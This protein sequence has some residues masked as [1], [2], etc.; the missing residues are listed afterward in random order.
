M[1]TFVKL[2][3]I[4]DTLPPYEKTKL[5][6]E[7]AERVS[8][9]LEDVYESLQDQEKQM[10]LE[11]HGKQMIHDCGDLILNTATYNVI[12]EYFSDDD[13][14]ISDFDKLSEID[15]DTIIEYLRDQGYKVVDCD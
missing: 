10:F 2:Q 9:C 4:I 1:F 8:V 7:G 13:N 11:N 14:Y 12:E 5:K 6:V 15:D 3:K